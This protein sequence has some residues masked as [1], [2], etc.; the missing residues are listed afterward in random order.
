MV[1]KR[2]IFKLLFEN[3]SFFLSRNFRL[4]KIGDFEWLKKN[5]DFSLIA[6][7]VDEII[8]LNVSR[9]E[10]KI[11]HFCEII[12][13]FTKECFIPISAGGKIV[14]LEIAKYIQSGA[15]KLVINSNL[16]NKILINKIA[17]TFGEQCIVGSLNY[18]HENEKFLFYKENG[19]LKIHLKIMK[20]LKFY[21][22]FLSVK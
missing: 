6:N 15:D 22:L 18:L 20:Y 12:K 1:K 11:D 14:S 16:F 19:N 13:K 4:Q 9:S 3:D 7:S 5:Y 21:Q 2:I 8:L 10:P 17:K